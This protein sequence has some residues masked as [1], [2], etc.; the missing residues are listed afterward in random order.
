[1][2][3]LHKLTALLT[4][5][6]LV[7]AMAACGTSAPASTSS[8]AP[9]D[10]SSGSSGSGLPAQVQAIKDRGVLKVGVKEDVPFFGLYN[11]ETKSY[12]GLEIELAKMI[13]KE[14]IGDE[15]A[16]E[17]TPVTAATRGQLVDSGD[18]DMVIATFTINDERK[19]SYNFS[20]PYYTD[21]VGL[22]VKKDG[23]IATVEDLDGKKVG[24]ATGANSMTL[25]S[26]VAD[27]KNISISFDEYA[28]YPEIKAALDSGRVD[29]FCVDGSILAGYLDDSTTI[30][31][32]RFAPQDYGVCTK[33][34]NKDLASY[35]DGLVTG[36]LDDGT[37]SG[38]IDSIGLV[39]SYTGE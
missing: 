7:L 8:S 5:A 21:A 28:S 39:P 31:D 26:A 11:T 24:V 23:G 14:I 29:A 9:A 2:K 17:F 22:L 33:L 16:V 27:E 30:L 38:I 20:T 18:V 35:V 10:S 15:N 13:A 25:L 34:D 3:T 1:M 19:L 6:L 4:A 12:E 36:W 32:Y 37:I